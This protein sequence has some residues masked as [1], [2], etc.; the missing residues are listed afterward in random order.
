MFRRTI[1]KQETPFWR[2]EE[3]KKNQRKNEQ[4]LESV[5]DEWNKADSTKPTSNIKTF[6]DE[7]SLKEG[8]VC[9]ILAGSL[10]ENLLVEGE[11]DDVKMKIRKLSEEFTAK[12]LNVNRTF[13]KMSNTFGNVHLLEEEAKNLEIKAFIG[14]IKELCESNT[15]AEIEKIAEN[16]DKEPLES[17]SLITMSFKLQKEESL[18]EENQD[19]LT[20]KSSDVILA[21]SV[22]YHKLSFVFG[23]LPLILKEDISKNTVQHFF[24]EPL[25][26]LL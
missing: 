11:I 14:C 23:S 12:C 3:E 21:E 17:D 20:Q 1:H 10:I 24:L 8:V 2:L 25:F 15:Q 6:E 19:F 22:K 9:D 26:E 5:E 18:K 13:D 16:L 4:F 7:L